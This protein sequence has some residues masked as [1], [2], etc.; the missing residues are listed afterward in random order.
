MVWGYDKRFPAQQM[1]FQMS[2]AA[3][4]RFLES[5][6]AW[7]ERKHWL[8]NAAVK[9]EKPCAF[10]RYVPEAEK[11]IWTVRAKAWNFPEFSIKGLGKKDGMRYTFDNAKGLCLCDI[12]IPLVTAARPPMMINF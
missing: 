4:Q 9:N 7:P 6:T 5:S 11:L 1:K 8:E 2:T 3:T 12:P 10:Y